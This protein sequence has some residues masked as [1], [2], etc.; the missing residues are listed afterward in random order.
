MVRQLFRKPWQ[1]S[2]LVHKLRFQTFLEVLNDLCFLDGCLP[3][4]DEYP[5]D[6]KTEDGRTICLVSLTGV[7]HHHLPVTE[8]HCPAV[9]IVS[10]HHFVALDLDG[11]VHQ[12]VEL[13]VQRVRLHLTHFRPSQAFKGDLWFPVWRL[14]RLS[15]LIG[16]VCYQDLKQTR[17]KQSGPLSLVE[18][19]RD[20]V[21]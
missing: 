15:R 17:D 18:I 4:K 7:L 8:T 2:E 19:P 12:V 14:S 13:L 5:E 11:D 21:L 16:H 3:N 6:G 20:T 10:F 9:Y 1:N